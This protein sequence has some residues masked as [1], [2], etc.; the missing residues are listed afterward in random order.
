MRDTR[1]SS[2]A[3]RFSTEEKPQTLPRQAPAAPVKAEV[4]LKQYD[5][6]QFTGQPIYSL[7]IGFWDENY[8][9]GDFREAAADY[10]QELR[11]K[12]IEA[13]LFHGRIRSLVT[14]NLFK[15][16]D[17]VP[18]PDGTTLYGPR[19]LELQKQFPYNL[20][21]GEPFKLAIFGKEQEHPQPSFLIHMPRADQVAVPAPR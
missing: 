15:D 21:N 18:Q 14:V 4:T 16:G 19:V 10:V 12:G 7:Q 6:A 20:S 3:K 11:R 13:Y 17:L 1:F 8:T 5:L 2:F 9:R